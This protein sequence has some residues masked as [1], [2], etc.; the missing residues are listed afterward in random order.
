MRVPA[1]RGRPPV[2]VPLRQPPWRADARLPVAAV[3]VSS[4]PSN[5]LPTPHRRGEARDEHVHRQRPRDMSE[6]VIIDGISGATT[7]TDT[8][9]APLVVSLGLYGDPGPHAGA[10]HAVN[11]KQVSR[12]S[13]APSAVIVSLGLDGDLARR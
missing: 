7:I 3:A 5:S 1:S 6:Q 8:T 4:L 11:L 12:P 9:H 2:F 10:P 13:T